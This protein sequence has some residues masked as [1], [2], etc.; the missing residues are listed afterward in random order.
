MAKSQDFGVAE[1]C[2]ADE[3]STA[4]A[5]CS[6]HSR[7]GFDETSAISFAFATSDVAFATSDVIRE[8]QSLLIDLHR[9][10]EME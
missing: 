3:A 9:K 7:G 5:S 10:I 4:I 6:L 1:G 8:L 2:V